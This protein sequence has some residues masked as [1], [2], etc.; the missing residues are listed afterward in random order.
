VFQGA[1]EDMNPLPQIAWDVR[2]APSALVITSRPY[3]F[4]DPTLT[5]KQMKRRALLDHNE[6][7]RLYGQASTNPPYVALFFSP[8]VLRD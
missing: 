6:V 2:F 5:K 7:L 8:P 4:S 3:P 1:P